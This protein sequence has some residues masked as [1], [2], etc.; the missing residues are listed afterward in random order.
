MGLQ[1]DVL[2]LAAVVV[3]ALTT[4]IATNTSYYLYRWRKTLPFEG[5][6]I[7]VPE[8][9]IAQLESVHNAVSGVQKTI[10]KTGADQ[11]SRDAHIGQ[12]IGT[13]NSAIG[14]L[15]ETTVSLQGALDLRDAEISRL[16][17]GYDA[18]L[19]RRF[20]TRF[21]R[22]K[23]AVADAQTSHPDATIHQIGRL[24]DDALDECGVEEFVPRIDDDFRTA[25]GVADS[26]RVISTAEE[27]Q[28]FKIAEILEPGYRFRSGGKESVLLP[29]RVSIFLAENSGA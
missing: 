7:T 28:H 21:I 15:F 29:A 27:A 4:A 5:K 11:K 12:T 16:K 2:M 6:V 22:V 10:A 20:V 8:E 23:I 19:I 17:Q 25:I 14:Q 24:L 18:E 1:I 13:T 3:M 9:L 26:R